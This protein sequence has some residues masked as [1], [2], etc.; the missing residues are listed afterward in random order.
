MGMPLPTRLSLECR[1]DAVA[2]HVFDDG[3][4]G[5]ESQSLG[6]RGAHRSRHDG[7]AFQIEHYLRALALIGRRAAPGRSQ[8][9]AHACALPL[10]FCGG[11]LISRDI[12][13]RAISSRPPRGRPVS[14]LARDSY[15]GRSLITIIISRPGYGRHRRLNTMSM[16]PLDGEAIG[17]HFEDEDAGKPLRANTRLSASAYSACCSIIAYLLA[18]TRHIACYRLATHG[19]SQRYAGRFMPRL[20]IDFRQPARA[21]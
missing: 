17:R 15:A 1:D 13:Y 7:C 6:Y 16:A 11:A 14:Y 20:H 19:H 21:R 18:P 2:F 3:F 5:R 8:R 4:D 10:S 12:Y 9:L